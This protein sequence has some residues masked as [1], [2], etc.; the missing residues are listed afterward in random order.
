MITRLYALEF[1]DYKYM[2]CSDILFQEKDSKIYFI[3]EYNYNS[4]EPSNG[5]T[6]ANHIINEVKSR[7][8]YDDFIDYDNLEIAFY[9]LSNEAWIYNNKLLTYS[10]LG[11]FMLT[12]ECDMYGNPLSDKKNRYLY[13]SNQSGFRGGVSMIP[14]NNINSP[15]DLNNI[16]AKTYSV[17][18]NG[19]LSLQGI[20][21][22]EREEFTNVNMKDNKLIIPASIVPLEKSNVK[23]TKDSSIG[24][25]FNFGPLN[26]SAGLK[27]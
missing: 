21:M 17:D 12:Q 1:D 10:Q 22:M 3:T 13:L 20:N 18:Y 8:G 14:A 9:T 19:S 26:I 4:N 5:T 23:E 2:I 15:N 16:L 25:D 24:V 11:K 6:V 7:Y 27:F